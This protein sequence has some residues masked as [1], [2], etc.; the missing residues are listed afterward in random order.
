MLHGITE[1]GGVWTQSPLHFM[2]GM[3]HCIHGVHNKHDLGFLFVVGTVDGE[4]LVTSLFMWF[5]VLEVTLEFL[6]P[7]VLEPGVP[8]V[9][10]RAEALEILVKLFNWMGSKFQ[11][12]CPRSYVLIALDDTLLRSPSVAGNPG[13]RNVEAVGS[14]DELPRVVASHEEHHHSG[15]G[16]LEQLSDHPIVGFPDVGPAHLLGGGDAD[17]AEASFLLKGFDPGLPIVPFG[18]NR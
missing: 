9:I 6:L 8:S 14:C 1:F 16:F 15:V 10:V 4:V 2:Q 17:V 11:G 12:Y 18:S 5:S 7:E 13:K 3:G